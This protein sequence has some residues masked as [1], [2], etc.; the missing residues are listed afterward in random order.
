MQEA[1]DLVAA[2][3]ALQ[4]VA[5]RARTASDDELLADLESVERLGRIV[6]GLRI[7]TAAEVERRSRKVLGQESLAFRSGARDG[8][9]L[10]QVV[11]RIDHRSAKARIGLGTA[12]APD[13]SLD[14]SP[15]PG[16]LPSVRDAIE[17]GRVGVESARVVVEAVREV[18]TRVAADDVEVVVDELLAVAGTADTEVLHDA[19][20]HWVAAIDPD[21][22]EP[23][24][25]VQHR[26][27]SVRI[28]RT[29]G[30]GTT[31]M[32]VVLPP[33]HLAVVKELL[34]SRRRGR[35]MIRV[36]A[37]D[38][39]ADETLGPGWRPEDADDRTTPQQDFDTLMET[40]VAG[41]AAEHRSGT[42]PHEVV[43]TITADELESRR[44]QG[45]TAGVLAG[46]PVP[47][48]ER[49]ACSGSIRL[50]VS[51]AAG[52]PLHLSR[53]RRVFTEAQKK[54]L[55]ARAQGRCQHPG[56]RTPAPYLE[57]HHAEWWHRD[58]GRTD[59]GNGLMLC[60]FHHHLVHAKRARVEIRKHAGRHWFV[61]PGWTGPPGP[62]HAAGQAAGVPPRSNLWR[63]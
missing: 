6:D 43:V 53:S 16:A 39:A 44:G 22:A 46:L 37:G 49:I 21:G 15:L 20:A 47:V 60:S 62:E 4:A 26:Q 11:A 54:A 17:A 34:A 12:L 2:L 38:D 32:A 1:P 28:G 7:R 55:L 24:E 59:V 3:A 25:A 27:R 9:E 30:D 57:A 52:E 41:T 42:V 19:A 29:S 58:G 33:E 23:R 10:V 48:V 13:A 40:L 35:G 51:D 14:G 63:R 50:L 31:R 5:C 45:W 36:E 18:R 8:V 56:C 61:P